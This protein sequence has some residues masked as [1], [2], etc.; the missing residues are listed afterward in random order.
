MKFR[1]V[2]SLKGNETRY[3]IQY[4]RPQFM[5]REERWLTFSEDYETI[6][7]IFTDNC[8]FDT[9]QEAEEKLQQIQNNLSKEKTIK[10]IKEVQL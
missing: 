4:F 7:G 1:I 5:W 6:M 10:V 3:I 8:V 2:E 9:L